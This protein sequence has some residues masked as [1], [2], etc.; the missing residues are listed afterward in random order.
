MSRRAKSAAVPSVSAVM[1]LAPVPAVAGARRN[2]YQSPRH[3]RPVE[4]AY[5]QVVV[6]VSCRRGAAR[7]CRRCAR[8]STHATM[9]ASL[10]AIVAAF[11]TQPPGLSAII[12]R[13]FIITTKYGGVI[14]GVEVPQSPVRQCAEGERRLATPRACYECRG[15][16]YGASDIVLQQ[17]P[18]SVT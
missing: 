17:P 14:H 15:G 4:T 3:G 18:K 10:F 5:A 12:P 1:L 13:S 9:S 11:S 8:Y 7:A 6:A 16:R 2:G